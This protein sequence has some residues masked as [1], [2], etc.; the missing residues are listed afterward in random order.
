MRQR[1]IWIALAAAA[2][3][4]AGGGIYLTRSR[5]TA[6]PERQRDPGMAVLASIRALEATPEG[7]LSSEQVNKILPFI[8]ALKDVPQSDAE[9]AAVI[10]EAVRQTFT[11]AQQAAL[12]ESRRRLQERR[13]AGAQAGG[14]FD[15]GGGDGDGGGGAGPGFGRGPGAGGGAISAEQRG[16][17]RTRFFERMI[18]YLERRTN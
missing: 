15:R 1:G 6:Q 9:A 12:E 3:V 11:P 2:I 18:R 14:G 13:R 5:S 8:K 16:Q 7:R 17:F 10:A 4:L